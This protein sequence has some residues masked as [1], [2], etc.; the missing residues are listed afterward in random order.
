M[1][2]YEYQ[3][4]SCDHEF[5]VLQKMS[6]GNLIDCPLCHKPELK[7]IISASAF[8]LKGSGWYAS[9][10]KNPKSSQSS[11]SKNSNGAAKVTEKAAE[12]TPA[13]ASCAN[14]GCGCS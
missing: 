9:D 11:D 1:P 6:D 5:E 8:H 10:F 13:K 14:V 12:K 7:K 4:K 2:I 3:C